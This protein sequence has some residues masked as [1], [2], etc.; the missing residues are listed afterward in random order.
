[1]KGLC[2]VL[3]ASI[4][5]VAGCAHADKPDPAAVQ[6]ATNIARPQSEVDS[7]GLAEFNQR[8]TAYAE[9]HKKLEATLPGMPKETTPEIIDTHQRALE[10]LVR[11]ARKD[12]RPGD[13]LTPATQKV[14]RQLLARVFQGQQGRELKGMILDE[15]PGNI[16][17]AVNARY[18]DTIPMST[19][20]PQV[21]SAFPKLPAELEY[22]FIGDRLILL[23]KH[24][25][26]IADYMTKVFP[27]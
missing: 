19:V 6:P 9:L 7:Q 12:A 5:T 8:V 20:P 11:G 16:G 22:R 27:V 2:A 14:F 21:L 1:M 13:L 3:A 18:P 17:L 23:D 24:A 15:N 4:L 25:H 10:Q 26:T